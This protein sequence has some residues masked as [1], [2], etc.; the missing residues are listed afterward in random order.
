M[1]FPGQRVGLSQ[2]THG[3]LKIASKGSGSRNMQRVVAEALDD[4]AAAVAAF[5]ARWI[6]ISWRSS[7]KPGRDPPR[8]TI[9]VLVCARRRREVQRGTETTLHRSHTG[10]ERLR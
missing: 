10:R 4:R 8:T 6:V 2:R 3:D 1:N 9:G 5:V 7:A